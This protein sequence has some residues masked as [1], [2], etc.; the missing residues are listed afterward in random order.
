MSPMHGAE[1]VGGCWREKEPMSELRLPAPSRR[2]RRS[3]EETLAARRSVRDFADHALSDSELSQLAW[4]AQG[5]THRDGYRT[6][7]S[8]GAL[9]PLRLYVAIQ[10]GFYRYDPDQH[11]LR[12]CIPGDM[13]ESIHQAALA[14]DAV[15]QAPAVFIVTGLYQ[16]IAQK[17]GATRGARY[18]HIEVGH[19]AQN[20]HLQAVALNLASVPVGAFDDDRLGEILALPAGESPLYVIPVGHSAS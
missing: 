10:T 12:R 7:P 20:L 19:A 15:L 1:A 14:Q 13:R 3:L 8:A 16:R 2:G 11:L 4:A 18:V 6:V 17:Y 5:M 9:Y